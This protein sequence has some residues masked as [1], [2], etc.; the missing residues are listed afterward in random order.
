MNPY[1][2]LGIPTAVGAISAGVGAARSGQN[3]PQ[4]LGATA[5]G[6]LAG[7]GLGKFSRFA[8][9]A[10][11][12]GLTAQAV[13]NLTKAG[14]TG[15][16]VQG[17]LPGIMAKTGQIGKAA[18]YGT[19][20]LFAGA[21][22]ALASGVTGTAG[23]VARNFAGGGGQ[24]GGGGNG[25]INTVLG[26]GGAMYQGNQQQQFQQSGLTQPTY[27]ANTGLNNDQYTMNAWQG[28]NPLGMYQTALR[29]TNQMDQQRALLANQ[30]GNWELQAGDTAKTRD[31]QRGAAAAS[32]MT[33]LG[34]QQGL[35]LEGQKQGAAMANQSIAD[36]GALARTQF[37]YF[38]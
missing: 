19:E 3:L 15:L 24:G 34:T 21:P 38:R 17:M 2:A 27:S 1:L 18:T 9:D 36:A 7:L 28:A 37:N 33:N 25:P 30:Y 23:N 20:A 12:G 4:V 22:G 32:L 11:A 6:G 13:N 10:L 8:G 26:A 35:I 14:Y 5:L 31:M 29:L 16:Q